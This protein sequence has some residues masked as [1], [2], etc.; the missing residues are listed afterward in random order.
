MMVGATKGLLLSALGQDL[1]D[2][3]LLLQQEGADDALP[4]ARGAGG[5]PVAPRHGPLALHGASPLGISQVLDPLEGRLAVAALRS[6]GGLLYALRLEDSAGG[7]DRP[8][9]VLLRVVRMAGPRSVPACV[10]HLLLPTY[11]NDNEVR[12][13]EIEALCAGSVC[14]G[15]LQTLCHAYSNKFP[16]ISLLPFNSSSRHT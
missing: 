10:R 13:C 2:G 4:D 6:F 1:L 7:A 5:A 3:L 12:G 9:A 8:V 11:C 14:A 15:G 16:S